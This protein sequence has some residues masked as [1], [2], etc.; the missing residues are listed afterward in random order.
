MSD[1][2]TLKEMGINNP[3]EIMRYTCHIHNNVD[4]LRIIYER[5]PGSFLPVT[6]R[7]QFGRSS[8]MVVADGGTNQY[9]TIYEISPILQKAL[10]ELDMVIE[11][12]NN[13]KNNKQHILE[14]IN[15]LES[16]FQSQ[17]Q[18]LKTLV[19]KL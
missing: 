18:S 14:E 1:F 5:K 7:Y 15:Q 11:Q 12:N 16:D 13:P 9:D 6:R 2:P 10:K 17:I 3:H 19:E 8:K 4:H